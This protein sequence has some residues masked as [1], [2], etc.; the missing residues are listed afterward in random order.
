MGTCS[1]IGSSSSKSKPLGPPRLPLATTPPSAT[2]AVKPLDA[3]LRC[4]YFFYK[5]E[6]T[7]QQHSQTAL[8]CLGRLPS[9]LILEWLSPQRPPYASLHSLTTISPLNASG[10]TQAG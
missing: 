1:P 6:R 8:L 7:K 10:T 5:Q 9:I 4:S 2:T 3:N